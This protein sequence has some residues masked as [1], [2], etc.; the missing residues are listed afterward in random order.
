MDKYSCASDSL[1][2]GQL[3]RMVA[4][5]KDFNPTETQGGNTMKEGKK[6]LLTIKP[7][8]DPEKRHKIQ[9]ALKK[10]GYDVR[11]GGTDEDRT[12]CSVSFN[13]A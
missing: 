13:E 10:L 5:I 1:R 12:R 11:G 7:A 2:P 3:D 9:D 6:Y 4:T 8:L